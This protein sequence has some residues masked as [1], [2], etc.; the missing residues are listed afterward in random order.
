MTSL[1]TPNPFET[2]LAAHIAQLTG[3]IG[4]VAGRG[5][6]VQFTQ[7]EDAS[8]YANTFGNVDTTNGYA[9]KFQYGPAAGPTTIMTVGK[10]GVAIPALNLL[11]GDLATTSTTSTLVASATKAVPYVTA[12]FGLVSTAAT[13]DSGAMRGIASA[14]T[15]L[16]SIRAGEFH[17]LHQTGF[18]AASG[19]YGVEIGVHSQVASGSNI[20]HN[21]IYLSSEPFGLS[22]S[23][24]ND[25]AI[26]ITGSDGWKHAIRY[27]DTN[28]TTLL[29][30][31]NQLGTL[32]CGTIVP[33]AANTYNLGDGV[34]NFAGVYFDT[35]MIGKKV[36][37]PATP[38]SGYSSIAP[39]TSEY[40]QYTTSAAATRRILDSGLF[41]AAGQFIY[42]S[43]SN[44]AATLAAGTSSQV[45]HG[46]STPSWGSVATAD[47]A[48]NAVTN[49]I[50][51]YDE[52]TDVLSG[53]AITA[54]VWLDVTANQ[55][56][57][58]ADANSI[59]ELVAR[60]GIIITTNTV[61]T[62]FAARL[63]IDSA[64]TPQN[65]K[66]GSNIL[67]VANQ[68]ASPMMG[69]ASVFV[70][71]LS[72][73]VH[74]VKLQIFSSVTGTAY[75]RASSLPNSEYVNLTVI[76]HKR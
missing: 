11:L 62:L 43:A 75:C 44:T 8:N 57:T 31:V 68:F 6:R 18:N 12:D 19:T 21:G 29:F 48:T 39:S 72:A 71:G 17:A 74:T 20:L 26:L 54:S 38:G 58:V 70:T 46:G 3:L 63:V 51:N 45:L 36:A 22:G 47:M 41:S 14:A 60:A 34:T 55:N 28:G 25:S 5:Q 24:R 16:G 69:N 64:G 35:A 10:G 67:Q 50:L 61:A 49:R 30:N 42:A 1:V 33:I 40:W 9:A 32:N 53:A 15:G 52:S 27:L 13:P 56:F 23:V 2:I 7:H 73:G 66:I 37:T 4:G 65:I 59:V 76:E